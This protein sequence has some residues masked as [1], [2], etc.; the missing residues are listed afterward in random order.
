M[1]LFE[2][3]EYQKKKLKQKKNTINEINQINL[4]ADMEPKKAMEL[5]DKPTER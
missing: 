4:N 5:L 1:I 3:L 2:D